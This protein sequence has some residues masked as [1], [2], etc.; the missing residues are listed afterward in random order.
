MNEGITLLG[1]LVVRMKSQVS[2]HPVTFTTW[3]EGTTPPPRL[4]ALDPPRW[5]PHLRPYLRCQFWR[6]QRRR[7]MRSAI[8]RCWRAFS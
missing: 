2:A 6:T 4:A 1:D 5:R 3:R 7:R 8:H